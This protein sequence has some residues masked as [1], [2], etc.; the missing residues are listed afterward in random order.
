MT[1][2]EPASVGKSF[3]LP[4]GMS[5]AGI[6]ENLGANHVFEDAKAFLLW[7]SG[8]LERQSNGEEGDLLVNGYANIFYV[9]GAGGAVFVVQIYW[10]AGDGKWCAFAS[11]LDHHWWNAGNRAFPRLPAEAGSAQAGN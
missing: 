11:R 4:H 8:A 5:D 10:R 9:R 2:T 1:D 6:R 3:D 7:L